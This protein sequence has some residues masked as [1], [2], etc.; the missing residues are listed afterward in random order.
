[1]IVNRSVAECTRYTLHI[2][3]GRWVAAD[4]KAHPEKRS[5]VD[6]GIWQA[7]V[8]ADGKVTFVPRPAVMT[9]GVA[10]R[11]LGFTTNPKKIDLKHD[12]HAATFDTEDGR[13]LAAVWTTG[14]DVKVRLA[15]PADAVFTDFGGNDSSAGGGEKEILLTTSPVYF[16]V[17]R[18]SRAA[19][20]QSLGAMKV[21]WRSPEAAKRYVAVTGKMPKE[22]TFVLAAPDAVYPP[23]AVMPEYGFFGRD[24]RYTDKVAPWPYAEVRMAWKAGGLAAEIRIFNKPYVA[25]VDKVRLRLLASD[26]LPDFGMEVYERT[27][28]CLDA[29]NVSGD[30][31]GSVWHFTMPWTSLKGMKAAAGAHVACNVICDCVPLGRTDKTQYALAN[32]VPDANPGVFRERCVFL[33]LK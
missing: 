22:P 18:A 9:C 33:E 4:I 29:K 30:E 24:L 32:D 20:E 1:M 31:K 25:G 19:F 21:T 26:G 6:L 23:M 17:P 11:K 3:A 8:R 27:P 16:T 28:V 7:L 12:L 5:A 10:A 15:V 14:A 2:L 13:T